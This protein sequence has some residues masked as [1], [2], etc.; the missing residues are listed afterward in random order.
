MI[1]LPCPVYVDLPSEG[2]PQ[3]VTKNDIMS[4]LILSLDSDSFQERAEMDE[5]NLF[6]F[7]DDLTR[8]CFCLHLL[9]GATLAEF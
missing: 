9:N 2:N 6:R 8:S 4:V 5:G 7:S 3:G 1:S